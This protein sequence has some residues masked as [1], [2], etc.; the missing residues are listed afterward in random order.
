MA[1]IAPGS[2]YLLAGRLDDANQAGSRAAALAAER[3]FRASEAKAL[4]LLG[5]ISLRLDPPLVSR[6]E[7]YYH[8]AL[9][10]GQELG[11]RPLVAHC[12]LGLS[13]LYR[14]ASK[15][16]EAKEQVEMAL[17]MYGDMD[18]RFWLE[19]AQAELDALG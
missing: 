6:A 4:R 11:M 12:H 17:A 3:G 5:E 2:V 9:E 19:L 13:Q 16:R 8:R 10:L 15:P 18:M 7:D 1:R 14:C